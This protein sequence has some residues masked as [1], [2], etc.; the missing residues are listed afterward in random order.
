MVA[1]LRADF[2]HYCVAHQALAELLRTGT[3]PVSAPGVGALFEMIDRPAARAGLTFEAGLVQRIVDE[4]GH[5]PGA[6]PLMALAL[7]ELY[8]AGHADTKL[9]HEEYEG[10]GGVQGA[11]SQRAESTFMS[12]DAEA[13]ATLEQ[14]FGS[15]LEVEKAEGRWVAVRRRVPLSAITPTPAAARLVTAFTNARLLI[16]DKGQDGEPV[17]EVAHEALLRNWPRLVS[18]IDKTADDLRLLGQL[19][20]AAADWAAHNRSGTFLW[21][22]VRWRQAQAM[23]KRLKPPLGE[24]QQAFLRHSR[25]RSVLQSALFVAGLAVITLVGAF[26]LWSNSRNFTP[27]KAL[28]ELAF[29]SR[30]ALEVLALKLG[31]DLVV[32]PE[33]KELS[34]STFWMGSKADD[35]DAN[36]NEK[37]QREVTIISFWIGKYEVTFDEYDLFARVLV[38]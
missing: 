11:I 1:T 24:S 15:L 10:F 5:E 12:L 17:V 16:Q 14:V 6:L 21:P 34:A 19:E 2:Y 3:Y 31:L 18:W 22:R 9:T 13:R 28:D 7:S 30:G 8:E 4:T 27:E 25:R 23:V 37:P 33:M 36:S 26:L 35:P 32:E 38:G 20:Q 29:R